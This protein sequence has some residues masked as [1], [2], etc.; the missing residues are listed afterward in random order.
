MILLHIANIDNVTF[1][2]VDIVVPQ[3]IKAQSKYVNVGLLNLR[4]VKIEGVEKQFKYSEP[5]NLSNLENP[6][7]KPDLVVF[8]ECY[9]LKYIAIAKT[10]RNQNIP[11]IIIPHGELGKEAQNSKKIKKKIANFMFFRSFTNKAATIQCLSEREC[12][13]TFFGKNK[14]VKTNGVTIPKRKKESFN[15]D[16][17]EY[18]YI[19]RLDAYH[20][21]L[22]LLFEAIKIKVGML[23]RYNA[24]FA[25]YGPDILGRVNHLSELIKEY[26]IGDL[27]SLQHQISGKEKEK[28]LLSAD[29]FIQT[30]RFEGM[31]LGILESMSYG[32]PNLVTEGTTLGSLIRD[33]KSG[34]MAE[35]SSYQIA[36]ILEKSVLDRKNWPIY[37]NNGRNIAIE[38]FSW[39]KIAEDTIDA[40][41]EIINKR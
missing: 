13:N 5:F 10:L 12:E 8:H 38:M 32:L 37:G 30:S 9:N 3:H 25:I 24:H 20:K 27:V 41:K 22:D 28:A 18:I 1:R 39:D 35:T 14:I 17:I 6:F 21:G 16:R 33:T 11:Y 2:G 26:E 36:K 29:I 31:P 15:K 40:Y 4:N 19:G 23:R 7:N 34:W